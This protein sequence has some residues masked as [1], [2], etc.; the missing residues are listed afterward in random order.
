MEDRGAWRAADHGLQ[1][2]QQHDLATEQQQSML[3]VEIEFQKSIV[4]L[5]NIIAIHSVY[6]EKLW[7]REWQPTPVFLPKEFHGQT[8]GLQRV[9]HERVSNTFNFHFRSEIL[10]DFV[11]II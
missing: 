10:T 9:R 1:R 2:V 11:S 6:S 5:I 7:R 8:M 3:G 4:R